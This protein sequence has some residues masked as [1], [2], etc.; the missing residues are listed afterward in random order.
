MS[1]RE[2]SRFLIVGM[3]PGL[4]TGVVCLNLDGKLVDVESRRGF[5]KGDAI[6]HIMEMGIPIV[7]A[8]DMNPPPRKVEK[9]AAAFPARLFCPEACLGRKEK[10]EIVRHLGTKWKNQHEKDAAAA[11]LFAHKHYK[12]TLQKVKIKL[13]KKRLLRLRGEVSRGIILK[14]RNIDAVLKTILC[15]KD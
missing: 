3:D 4:T 9:I 6:S 8:S 11:A 13:R 15:E 5:S 12:R 14:G 7:V 10:A 2:G 1:E